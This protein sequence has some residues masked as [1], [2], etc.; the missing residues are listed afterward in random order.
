MK[1]RIGLIGND[2][3]HVAIFA[4]M[5][6]DITNPYY[7]SHARFA[8]YIKSYSKDMPISRDRANYFESL[9]ESFHI[10]CYEEIER[11]NEKVDAWMIVTIDGRNHLSWFEKI[12]TFQKPVYID[13]PMSVSMDSFH[14]MVELADA[15]GTPVFSSSSLRFSEILKGVDKSE[16]KSLYAFGPLPMQ[17]KMPGYYWYGIHTLEWIDE[18]F[19]ADVESFTRLK[20]ADYELLKMQFEDGRQAIFRGEHK[21]NDKFGGVVHF[22]EEPLILQFWK[23][24]KPYYASLLEHILAFFQTGR[25]PVNLNRTKRILGWIEEINKR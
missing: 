18:V 19:N 25:S 23:M 4:H 17:D 5:L 12:V 3:T 2:T 8:G 20:F 1:M 15:H 7:H 22:R 9:L 10:P 14:R 6:H 13:K 24:E 11:L 16:V 21:W